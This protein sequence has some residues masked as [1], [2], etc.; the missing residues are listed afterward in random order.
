MTQ[1]AAE[2]QKERS[3][4]AATGLQTG[5]RRRIV[6]KYGGS[7]ME[8]RDAQLAAMEDIIHLSA[9][10]IQVILVHGGGP[11]ITTWL[12][13][14]GKQAVF[15]DGL[16]VT[17][18][19]TMEV[20]QMVLAGKISKELVKTIGRLGGKAIGLS[21]MDGGMIRAEKRDDRLGFVGNIVE[22]H[23]AVILDLLHGGYIPV[24]G[25]VGFDDEGNSYNIN[26]DT[27]AAEIAGALAADL[28]LSMTDTP[29]ILYDLN[30]SAS[31]IPQVAVEEAQGLMEK[32]VI[33]GGMMPKVNC[34]IAAIRQG[35]KKV[36]IMDGRMPHVIL[37]AVT[38]GSD[39]GIGTAVV[40][41]GLGKGEI[42]QMEI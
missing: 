40:P 6:I 35:V 4:D 13:R 27:A 7:I 20:V 15:E 18:G 2:Q 32:G 34:C 26:A 19:E 39:S 8:N 42:A 11:E 28:L 1:W 25:A 37:R 9:L 3:A 31:L 22:I 10:G 16:R 21:G 17:D 33:S 29:G 12:N 38:E 23:P 24:I 14:L 5:Q 41:D 30:D 36:L